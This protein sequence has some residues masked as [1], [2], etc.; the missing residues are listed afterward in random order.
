MTPRKVYDYLCT[1]DLEANYVWS[2]PL[3]FRAVIFYLNR[4][5]PLLDLGVAFL[6][7][8]NHLHTDQCRLLLALGIILYTIGTMIAEGIL[9]MRTYAMWGCDRNVVILFAFL[10]AAG[11]VGDVV[12]ITKEFSTIEF[13]EQDVG[14]YAIN[15]DG[16]V[17]FML[18]YL[19]LAVTETVIAVLSVV[20]GYR[21][22]A[23]T[24]FSLVAR[25]GQY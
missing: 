17:M 7:Q 13:L 21:D 5:T 20:K 8:T 16:K 6:V 3:A 24:M 22:R 15:V 2:D 19:L 12:V 18:P 1:V 25:T 10:L 9:M 14:C 4:Y 23:Y 11:L